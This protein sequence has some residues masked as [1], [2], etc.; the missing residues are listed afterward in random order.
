MIPRL[1]NN[2]I[3]EVNPSERS[4]AFHPTTGGEPRCLLNAPHFAECSNQN[5]AFKDCPFLGAQEIQVARPPQVLL[6]QSP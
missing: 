6:A 2:M 3:A 1:I 4:T 5:E